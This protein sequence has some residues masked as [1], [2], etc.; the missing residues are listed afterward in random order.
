MLASSAK[1]GGL[2][3]AFRAASGVTAGRQVAACLAAS[4]RGSLAGRPRT[5]SSTPSPECE[6]YVESTIKL[7]S[8]PG[9][10]SHHTSSWY[11]DTSIPSMCSSSCTYE[12]DRST[13]LPYI[14]LVP[15]IAGLY[16]HLHS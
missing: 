15:G 11:D 6:W 14:H 2:D 4:S 16:G 5:L 1:R 7:E 12:Y 10:V 3:V 13:F 8:P 9:H